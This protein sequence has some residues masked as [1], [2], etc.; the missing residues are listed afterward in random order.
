MIAI[1]PEG[2][3]LETHASLPST[4]ITARERAATGERGPL[5]IHAQRQ[6]A[7]TG[8]RGRPW[9]DIPGNFSATLLMTPPDPNQAALRSF[10]AALALRDAFI[11]QTGRTDLF[12]LK[13]PNDVLLKGR[14]VAGI[15]LEMQGQTLTIGIGVNLAATP[16]MDA[17]ETNATPPI[18]LREATGVTVTTDEFLASLAMAFQRWETQFLTY[19]FEPIRTAWLNHAA[20]LGGIVTARMPNRTESGTFTTIDSTGAIVL[21][22][23]KG[24]LTLPAADIF[25]GPEV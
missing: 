24:K 6:T 23:A 15:L 9:R 21:Q 7:G 8:R 10:I 16:A 11:E 18:S 14:K 3:G 22:T 17:L 1:W 13:W 2:V 20:Q 25:F 4:M 19:G 5:W 12:T